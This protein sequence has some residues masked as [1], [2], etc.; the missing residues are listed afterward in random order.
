LAF[1]F[2]GAVVVAAGVRLSRDGD[3]IAEHTGLG[4]AWIGAVLVA[5][6]TSL[7]ELMTDYFA[8]RQGE[9][10]LAIG[11]LFGSSMANMLIL[12]LADLALR[13][14]QILTRV[15]VNQALV[16]L[17]AIAL[18]AVAAAGV[19]TGETLTLLGVGWAPLV[20]AVSYLGGM[21]LLHV[22]RREPPFAPATTAPVATARPAGEAP[23]L[24]RAALGFAIAALLI[25]VAAPTLSRSAAAIADQFGVATGV[26]GVALL[27]VTTSL[28][29]VTV[30]VAA[31]RA[32]SYDLAVGNLLGSNCFNMVLLLPLDLVDGGGA[33]LSG[34]GPSAQV[35]A[36]FAIL[37]TAQ[38]L[39]EVLN[40]AERRVWWLEP[41]AAL[42]VLT[43]ALGIYLVFQAG[44]HD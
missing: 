15:A 30:T 21:R 22:T 20:I 8:V 28:P 29:E 42:R 35:A 10:N 3:V 12:A 33:L 18:T 6:A 5:A 26:V 17:L 11:D 1:L 23:S 27:A 43:Y 34:V 31:M 19:L 16:G 41:D 32:G 2:S 13:R 7:P 44:S 4:R 37:L 40:V 9:V 38:T 36:L 14:R 25:L 39:I 24:P